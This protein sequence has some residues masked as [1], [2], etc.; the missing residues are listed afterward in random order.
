MDVKGLLKFLKIEGLSEHLSGY[1][2]DK[3]ELLKLELQEDGVALGTKL[4]FFIGIMILGLCCLLFVSI[5][6]AI[7]LNSIFDHI[8]I[9]YFIVA[10]VY[11]ILT[12]IIFG[13]KNNDKIKKTLYRALNEFFD[14]SK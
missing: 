10:G 13:L 9:G 6:F 14:K 4:L 2:E 12:L 7:F 8:F 3:I 5:G 11:L 1:V